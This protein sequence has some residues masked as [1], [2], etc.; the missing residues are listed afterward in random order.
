MREAEL[1]ESISWMRT[2]TEQLLTIYVEL[3]LWE[4]DSNQNTEFD[5]LWEMQHLIG[6][7]G[8]LDCFL[9]K[10]ILN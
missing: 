4:V 5:G 10:E 6:P 3:K 8:K 9:R 2:I 7:L 1:R